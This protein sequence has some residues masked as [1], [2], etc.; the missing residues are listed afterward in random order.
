LCRIWRGDARKRSVV[1]IREALD[2][3]SR[4][5][6]LREQDLPGRTTVPIELGLV[7][8]PSRLRVVE[9]RLDQCG[10]RRRA[11]DRV[12]VRR[13]RELVQGVEETVVARRL[14]VLD[15]AA[16]AV[17]AVLLLLAYGMKGIIQAARLRR[18]RARVGTDRDQLGTGPRL[19]GVIERVTELV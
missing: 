1:S 12:D 16:Q 6:A 19:D 11:R 5:A 17:D 7:L 3:V 15:H 9:R 2:R 18:A 4:G 8:L 13:S 14:P 10:G